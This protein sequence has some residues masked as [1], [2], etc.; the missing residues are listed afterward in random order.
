MKK[1]FFI[2]LVLIPILTLAQ[3]KKTYKGN[4][5]YSGNRGSVE[6]EYIETENGRTLDGYFK[7]KAEYGNSL[8]GDE[9]GYFKKGIK[10]GVWTVG[11]SKVKKTF[12][13]GNLNGLL[14][15]KGDKILYKD[16]HFAG[17]FSI[18]NSTGQFDSKGYADGEWISYGRSNYSG[19]SYKR[20]QKWEHGFLASDIVYDESTGQK[21][22]LLNVSENYYYGDSWRGDE[23]SWLSSKIG[24]GYV[25]SYQGSKG[26]AGGKYYTDENGITFRLLYFKPNEFRSYDLISEYFFGYYEKNELVLK[27]GF[28]NGTTGEYAMTVFP[29]IAIKTPLPKEELQKIEAE[30]KKEQEKQEKEEK[31]RQ[32]KIEQKERAIQNAMINFDNT[33]FGKILSEVRVKMERGKTFEEARQEA[34][35]SQ[36]APLLI[37]KFVD[38]TAA[39]GL[40][41]PLKV[42]YFYKKVDSNN[43]DYFGVSMTLVIIDKEKG[44]ITN[45]AISNES[46]NFQKLNSIEFVSPNIFYQSDGL[47]IGVDKDADFYIAQRKDKKTK[48]AEKIQKLDLNSR[49]KLKKG[50]YYIIERS[51]DRYTDLEDFLKTITLEEVN[52]STRT[53]FEKAFGE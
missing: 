36:I 21:K 15:H 44:W 30:R 41:I 37:S 4:Y 49:T 26:F 2:L 8:H 13:N 24:G 17:S 9:E 38:K 3:E 10:D 35:S 42:D 50:I 19:V 39:I 31:E 14:E 34:V 43:K 28:R 32:A 45:E 48:K 11:W 27:S 53:R 7:F 33:A 20:T 12:I 46:V 16:N 52:T 1:A 5:V 6:Y 51:S 23:R 25:H 18:G 22:D 47:I 40:G 29:F